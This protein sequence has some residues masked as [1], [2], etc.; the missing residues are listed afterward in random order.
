MRKVIILA[1]VVP[2]YALCMDDRI[3][4]QDLDFYATLEALTHK[5]AC[6]EIARTK[7][8][9]DD[10]IAFG[11]L[12]QER[13]NSRTKLGMQM[14]GLVIGLMYGGGLMLD[15]CPQDPG[16]G[17]ALCRDAASSLTVLGYG[18]LVASVIEMKKDF[19]LIRNMQKLQKNI[20][21]ILL[22]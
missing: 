22:R 1:L 9:R 13:V 19:F 12:A 15:Y 5:K 8:G 20:D 2:L 21:K 17:N 11:G 7:E 10:L 6:D 18:L 3:V 4:P 14:S 16:L